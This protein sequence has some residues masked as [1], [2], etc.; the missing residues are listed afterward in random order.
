MKS[1]IV[2]AASYMK[3]AQYFIISSIRR[4]DWTMLKSLCIESILLPNVYSCMNGESL[5]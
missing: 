4:A 1:I 5:K 3:Y 2:L